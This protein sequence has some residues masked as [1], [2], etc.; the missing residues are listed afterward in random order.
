MVGQH[1]ELSWVLCDDLVGWGGREDQ[2]GGDIYTHIADSLHGA[3]ETNT[4]L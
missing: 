3:V 2:E 4:P 1:R